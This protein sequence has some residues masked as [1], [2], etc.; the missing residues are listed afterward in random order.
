MAETYGNAT[1]EDI[2]DKLVSKLNDLVTAMASGYN[3]K[4]SYVYDHHNVANC[5]FNAVSVSIESADP[6]SEA[7]GSAGITVQYP[8]GITVRVHTA[9]QGGLV[10]E[11]KNARLINSVV[12]YLSKYK[13]LGGGYRVHE[14][15]T[16]LP[17]EEFEESHTVGGECEVLVTKFVLHT[18]G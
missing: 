13:D 11:V 6:S 8:C 15:K 17:N 7:A 12:N 2:R 18:Q 4:I 14:V 1:L 3:P 9:Y 10:D 5:Q 16:I